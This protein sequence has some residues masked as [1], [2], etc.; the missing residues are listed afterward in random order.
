MPGRQV[1]I[2]QQSRFAANSLPECQRF[3]AGCGAARAIPRRFLDSPCYQERRWDTL[4]QVWTVVETVVESSNAQCNHSMCE[5]VLVQ[6]CVQQPGRTA[7]R[8]GAFIGDL[9]PPIRVRTA[10]QCMGMHDYC[11]NPVFRSHS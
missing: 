11:Q 6:Q 1:I 5:L 3:Q 8:I 4:T 7:V 9:S 10:C 2:A